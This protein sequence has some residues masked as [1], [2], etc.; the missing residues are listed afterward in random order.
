MP[1]ASRNG[2]RLTRN[3]PITCFSST[4]SPLGNSPETIRRTISSWILSRRVFFRSFSRF[5]MSIND[6][7]TGSPD[8]LA[9]DVPAARQTISLVYL[10]SGPGDDPAENERSKVAR[11]AL[12]RSETATYVNSASLQL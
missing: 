3:L 6:A 1:I 7:S 8:G 4:H 12:D 9:V 11:S 10:T 5:F 2:V